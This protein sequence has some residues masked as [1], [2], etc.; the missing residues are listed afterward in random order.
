MRINH[1]FK[2]R[3]GRSRNK[4]SHIKAHKINTYLSKL[5][6]NQNRLQKPVV[7]KLTSYAKLN[8]IKCTRAALYYLLDEVGDENKNEGISSEKAMD[9]FD[10]YLHYIEK[11]KTVADLI[12]KAALVRALRVYDCPKPWC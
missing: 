8:K 4:K 5:Y 6:P 11:N 1:T 7:I 2:T 3:Q 9:V 10:N 12:S